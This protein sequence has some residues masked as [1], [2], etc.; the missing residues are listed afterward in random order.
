MFTTC[1]TETHTPYDPDCPTFWKHKPVNYLRIT[2]CIIQ[3]AW[4]IINNNPALKTLKPVARKVKYVHTYA[5]VVANNNSNNTFTESAASFQNK[6]NHDKNKKQA[7][8]Q[9]LNPTVKKIE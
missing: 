7:F 2:R 3:Q 5:H 4:E 8:Q 9:T 1:Q 6:T